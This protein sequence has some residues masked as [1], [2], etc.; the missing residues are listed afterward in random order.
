MYVG[1]IFKCRQCGQDTVASSP[2]QLY[3]RECAAARKKEADRICKL[4]HYHEKG[5]EYRQKLAQ[6][7]Q[8]KARRKKALAAAASFAREN[9][10]TYGKCFAPAVI[11]VIPAEFKGG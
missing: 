8:E 7:K 11:V 3:C 10:Q 6:Q 9:G 1:Q 2:S 5:K 4:K